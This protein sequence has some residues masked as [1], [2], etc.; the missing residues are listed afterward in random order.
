MGCTLDLPFVA[1]NQSQSCSI[2]YVN[3][4]WNRIRCLSSRQMPQNAPS[5][6]QT[7]AG[8][9]LILG[10]C[11]WP[12]WGEATVHQWLPSQRA[13]NMKNVSIWWCHHDIQNL[14]YV[15]YIRESSQTHSYSPIVYISS[16]WAQCS[17]IRFYIHG[18]STS[19]RAIALVWPILF[20]V[21]LPNTQG[22]LWNGYK[23]LIQFICWI[24][25]ALSVWYIVYMAINIHRIFLYFGFISIVSCWFD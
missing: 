3:K 9:G 20:E 2:S 22:G 14:V 7:G 17:P 13:S 23:I 15:I 4:L 18:P 24:C 5:G 19:L 10:P 16:N 11:H 8:R 6:A 25:I 21:G 12:L 1:C